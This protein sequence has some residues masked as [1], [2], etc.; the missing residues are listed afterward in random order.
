MKAVSVIG[1][2][3]D[4]RIRGDKPFGECWLSH[5]AYIALGSNLGPRRLSVNRA[6]AALRADPGVGEVLV[7][8]FHTTE[9][10]GGPAGQGPYLNAAAKIETSHGP[11]TLLALLL[12]IE[13]SL[14]RVRRERWGPRTIDLDLLLYDDRVIDL[15]GLTVPH[16]RMHERRFVL[17]PLAEIAGWVVHPI[18]G[19]SVARLLAELLAQDRRRALMRVDPNSVG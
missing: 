12:A 4:R 18:L 13:Q 11:E 15:P 3:I 17:E 19:K 14:G 7:S 6:V 8:S 10:V 16:P 1:G 2:R 9:P 5:T